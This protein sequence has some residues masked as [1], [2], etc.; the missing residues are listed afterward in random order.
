[1]IL[2]RVLFQDDG[3]FFAKVLWKLK[4]VI[5]PELDQMFCVILDDQ[6]SNPGVNIIL[7]GNPVTYI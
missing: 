2:L 7:Y 3:E 6:V 5:A 1:M 4:K